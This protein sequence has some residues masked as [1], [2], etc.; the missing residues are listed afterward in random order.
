VQTNLLSVIPLHVYCLYCF[1]AIAFKKYFNS[2]PCIHCSEKLAVQGK[3]A[4]RRLR[5]GHSDTLG[6]I[7]LFILHEELVKRAGKW[8]QMTN[9]VILDVIRL[10]I[11]LG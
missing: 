8:E 1:I 3:R 11:N 7:S 6:V 9:I 4:G 10:E 2:T 5:D